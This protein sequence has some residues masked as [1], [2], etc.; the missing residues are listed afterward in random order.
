M[1]GSRVDYVMS[2]F[3]ITTQIHATYSDAAYHGSGE[4]DGNNDD[5]SARPFTHFGDFAGRA[6]HLDRSEGQDVRRPWRQ[7]YLESRSREWQR[8]PLDSDGC[9]LP[10]TSNHFIG[11]KCWAVSNSTL[12]VNETASFLAPWGRKNNGSSVSAKG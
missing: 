12:L 4:G 3:R 11:V 5:T 1:R 6:P 8:G 10:S 9:L 7:F 2:S